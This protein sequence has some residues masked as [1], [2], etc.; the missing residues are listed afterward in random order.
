[1]IV[2]SSALLAILRDEPEGPACGGDRESFRTP[3]FGRQFSG[4][5]DCHGR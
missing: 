1:M 5:G 4:D 2:D 3:H